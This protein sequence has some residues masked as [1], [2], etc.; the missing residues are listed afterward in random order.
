MSIWI[1]YVVKFIVSLI[2]PL[3]ETFDILG[4]KIE[5]ASLGPFSNRDPRPRPKA[6]AVYCL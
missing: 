2:L 1:I 5:V 4:H 3:W 6:G